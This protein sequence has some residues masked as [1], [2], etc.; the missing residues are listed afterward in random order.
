MEA[1]RSRSIRISFII[2]GDLNEL[3]MFLI[4]NKSEEN[5]FHLIFRRGLV[6]T[7]KPHS[8]TLIRSLVFNKQYN[9]VCQLQ[10]LS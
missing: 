2:H 7:I 4:L 5:A 9:R 3:S 6:W 10:L 1:L 8:E